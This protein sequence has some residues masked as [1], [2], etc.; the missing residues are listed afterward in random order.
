MRSKL[1]LAAAAVLLSALVAPTGFADTAPIQD[2]PDLPWTNPA[3]ASNL[4]L[5][6]GPIASHIAGR[7]VAVRCEGDTDWTTLVTQQGRDPNSELGYVA[8]PLV[9][10]AGKVVSLATATELGGSKVCLPLKN[11]AVATT[12]PTKCAVTTM[13]GGGF[14][15]V[16]VKSRIAVM[17][18]GKP[19]F[20]SVWVSKTVAKPTK[21][22]TAAPSPCYLGG[23][24]SAETMTH[25]YWAD[26]ANYA[27]AI[28]TLAHESIHLSGVFGVGTTPAGVTVG[29]PL[30]EAKANC[31]GMQWMPYVAMQL[32]DTAD[33]ALA[34]AKYFWETIYPLYETSELSQYWSADC[35]PGGALDIRAAGTT[36]WP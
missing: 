28:V 27:W 11:F 20:K 34:I 23:K 3:H 32:G 29:D 10:N 1:L 24:Q 7:T 19:T 14:K 6:L 30:A 26:Y 22:I 18:K 15:T 2:T 16:R 25:A 8:G 17:V 35:K 9:T 33:D 12:K 4:E 13:T 5:L 21:R 31:Y 36:S